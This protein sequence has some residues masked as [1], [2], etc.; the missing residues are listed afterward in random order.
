LAAASPAAAPST[1]GATNEAVA[2]LRDTA[3][4]EAADAVVKVADDAVAA[5]R[6]ATD[7]E[8]A[9][10]AAEEN[11]AADAKTAEWAT[12]E[13]A[14]QGVVDPSGLKGRGST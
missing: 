10:V 4:S 7:K 5:E 9:D 8:A 1:F 12:P 2:A 11:V 14:S 6:V 3:E 13:A